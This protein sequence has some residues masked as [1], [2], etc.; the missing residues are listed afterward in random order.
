MCARPK[1][2]N[3]EEVVPTGWFILTPGKTELSDCFLDKEALEDLRKILK[4]RL[5]T[6]HGRSELMTTLN[7]AILKVE[8]GSGQYLWA[9]H[10]MHD[11][12]LLLRGLKSEMYQDFPNPQDIYEFSMRNLYRR[13][14][15]KQFQVSRITLIQGEL[16][17]PDP[18]FGSNPQA[19][20]MASEVPRLIPRS[21]WSMIPLHGFHDGLHLVCLSPDSTNYP[22]TEDRLR[23]IWNGT[24]QLCY[25]EAVREKEARK[26]LLK[27]LRKS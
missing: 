13:F 19:G 17:A 26:A 27:L 11:L 22:I 18:R 3:T 2:Q 15:K 24:R 21:Q 23:T 20:S 6:Y 14:P 4:R 25:Q 7:E 12:P 16:I 5:G 8:A 10:S 1:K 9:F